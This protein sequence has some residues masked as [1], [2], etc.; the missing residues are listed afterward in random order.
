MRRILA[1]LITIWLAG[2]A[3]ACSDRNTSG[4]GY[5]ADSLS[6]TG[7]S[8]PYDLKGGGGNAEVVEPGPR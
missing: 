8:S 2:V 1:L 4:S 6:A 3:V 7:S 5:G